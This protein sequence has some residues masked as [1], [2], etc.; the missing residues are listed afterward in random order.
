[1]EK[2]SNI[3]RGREVNR[4]ARVSVFR[5]ILA[6][7]VTAAGGLSSYRIQKDTDV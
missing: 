7:L 1:M 4:S 2:I 3:V 6:A 5:I